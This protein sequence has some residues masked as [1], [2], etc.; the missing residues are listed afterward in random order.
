MTR[1]EEVR[2]QLKNLLDAAPFRPFIIRLENGEQVRVEH[3]ENI[4]YSLSPWPS[5]K[6]RQAFYVLTEEGEVRSNLGAITSLFVADE[7]G[8]AG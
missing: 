6:V 1:V 5:G 7:A 8:L 3:P 2:L 4:A